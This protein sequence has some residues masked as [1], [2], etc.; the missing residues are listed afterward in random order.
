MRN[1]SKACPVLTQVAAKPAFQEASLAPRGCDL[2]WIEAMGN[3]LGE[4]TH[5]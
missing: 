5:S 2:P 3:A 1:P 4:K